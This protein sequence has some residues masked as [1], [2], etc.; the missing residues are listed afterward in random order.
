[1]TERTLLEH[2][3]TRRRFLVVA[4]EDSSRGRPA[5]SGARQ[6]RAAVV[7]PALHAGH[8]VGDPLPDGFVLWTRLAPAPLEG[9][10]MPD[11]Q[12]PVHREVARDES[13]RRIVRRGVESAPPEG[14]G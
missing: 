1:M 6:G 4:G 3:V 13:F 12:V 8:R 11:R 5:Q 10:G 2:P 14:R 9:G 7:A